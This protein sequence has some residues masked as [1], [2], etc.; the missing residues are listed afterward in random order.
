VVIGDAAKIRAQMKGYGPV[1][2]MALTQPA[3]EPGGIEELET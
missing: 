3:F 1:V 2:E